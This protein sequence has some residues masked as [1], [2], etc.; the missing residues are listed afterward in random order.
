MLTLDKIRRVPAKL[1]E[2]APLVDRA[3]RWTCGGGGSIFMFHRVL[4]HG[5]ECYEPE[6][7][8]SV[9]SFAPFLDWITEN[10]RVLPLEEVATRLGRPTDRNRPVCALTFDDGWLDNFQYAFPLIRQRQLPATI[11]LPVRFVGTDRRF[12]QE[13]IWLCF[14]EM[15]DREFRSA[16][17]EK[18]IRKFPWFPPAESFRSSYAALKKFLMTRS[19][20]EA[21]EFA[22]G[23]AE[24]SGLDSCSLDRTFVNWEEVRIMQASG[25][26]FGSHTLHHSLLTNAMPRAVLAELRNSFEELSLRLRADV[27][28]FSYPWGASNAIIQEQVRESG[29]TFAVTTQ[30]GLVNGDMNPWLLPR[31]AI[32]NSVLHRGSRDFEPKKSRL[33]LAKSIIT[34]RK[35]G[36]RPSLN[37]GTPKRIKISFIIDQIAGW[38]GGTERQ[39]YILIR[40][41]DPDYFEPELICIFRCSEVPRD[42][43]PCPVH[44]ICEDEDSHS[45]FPMRLLRLV[46]LLRQRKPHVVQTYFHE[47]TTLGLFAAWLAG[48][49]TLVG[50]TRNSGFMRNARRRVELQLIGGI[51]DYWQCNSPSVWTYETRSMRISPS[52]LEILPNAV[53]LAWFSPIQAEERAARRRLLGLN[54]SG[55]VIVSVANYRAVKDLTTLV[56]AARRVHQQLPNAQFLLVG[57]G[58]LGGELK[59]QIVACGLTDVV[60]LVGDQEDVRPFLAA[61]DIGVLTSL[62]EGCSNSLLEYMAVGLPVVVSDIPPNRD[63]VDGVFFACG[64]AQEL[65]EKLSGLWLDVVLAKNLSEQNRAKASQYGLERFVRRVEGFYSRLS[66]A[67]A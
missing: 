57:D 44:F 3:A 67:C 43:F 63:L 33:S 64:N 62:S 21:D 34:Q 4:P 30:A 20:E 31:F 49:P 1:L 14:K 17:L 65:S 2:G 25:I 27:S 32:S 15:K 36:P 29:Y 23:V 18:V 5:R 35:V 51:A 42:S 58:P 54:L 56:E 66:Q 53:D 19:S 12:W 50:T 59:Q 47:A 7:V 24:F 61:A 52:K 10:Y 55:P 26:S 48:V 37:G 9:D 22:R 11:F 39:L 13:L 16:V 46:H 40:M 6:L 8:T 45:A 28:G 60:R 38:E 41:L